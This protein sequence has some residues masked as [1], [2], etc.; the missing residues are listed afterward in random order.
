VNEPPAPLVQIRDELEAARARVHALADGAGERLAVRPPLGGWSAAE[1]IWHLTQTTK[2]T[3]PNI[4]IA[5]AARRV[6]MLP[7]PWRP[8]HSFFGWLLCRVLE[9]PSRIKAKTSPAFEPRHVGPIDDVLAD[10]DGQQDALIACLEACATVDIARLRMTSAFSTRVTYSV[11]SG[12]RILAT[13]Q[14]RHLWQAE[15]ALKA[16]A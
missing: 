15:A 3:L 16:A 2:L 4:K 7:D 6:P 1:C 9:P 14:R 5:L 10:F 12:F 11:Y 13:H 8:R